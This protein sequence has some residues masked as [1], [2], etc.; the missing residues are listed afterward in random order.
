MIDVKM[1]QLGES[2]A[3]G[4][5]TKWRCQVGDYVRREQPLVE[6][7]TDKADSELPSPADGRVAKLAVAEGDIVPTGGL[8][9]V[10]DES[11]TAPSPAAGGAAGPGASEPRAAASTPAAAATPPAPTA[12]PAAA[13]TPPAAPASPAPSAPSA[14]SS[15]ATRKLAREQGVDL[16]AVRGTGEHGRITREDVRSAAVAPGSESAP[17]PTPP[18]APPPTAPSA[19]GAVAELLAVGSAPVPVPG[20]G[21]RAYKVPPYVPRP[22]DEVV[23]FSRRRRITADHMVYSVHTAPHVVTVAEIDLAATSRLRDAHKA[24]FEKD[25]VSLTFLAFV[26]AA[27]TRALREHP[28]LNARVLDDA[29]VVL[30]DIHVGIAIDTPG[31]LLVAS[32]K[33]TGELSVRG[34]ARAIDELAARARDGKVT[35]DDLSGTTFTV[36]NPGRKGNL[37]G[38]AIISQPNVAILRIGEIKKRP[39]VVT[40]EGEDAIVIHPVM[41]AAL[42]YDHRVVDGVL[43][44][45]FLWR[46]ADVL[47]RA[48][49]EL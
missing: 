45:S 4:T 28:H 36:S 1:P 40:R 5:V 42:S 16:G 17:A 33:N 41:Y 6:V 26:V 9:C 39:V 48:E 32:I 20:A 14:L 10:L 34:I 31:G 18:P 19:V 3:E 24:A 49:F 46:V 15:P 30:R 13:A 38:G 47:G 21:Y 27:V 43:A 2:V 22:G 8:L 12:A 29:F 7:A 23:P 25:G 37:Y 35:A 44:N 11:A